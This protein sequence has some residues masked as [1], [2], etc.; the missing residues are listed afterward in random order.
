MSDE[1][2]MILISYIE[3]HTANTVKFCRKPMVDVKREDAVICK[4]DD[5][6]DSDY[7]QGSPHFFKIDNCQVLCVTEGVFFSC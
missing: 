2:I 6:N 1:T 4:Y 5:S 3:Q 7:S